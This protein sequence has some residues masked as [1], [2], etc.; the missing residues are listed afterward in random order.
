[1]VTLVL[2][3]LTQPL[4]KITLESMLFRLAPIQ[5]RFQA[6]FVGFVGLI[7]CGSSF[8]NQK[9]VLPKHDLHQT[10]FFLSIM[11][12]LVIGWFFFDFYRAIP[13]PTGFLGPLFF[14]GMTGPQQTYLNTKHRSPQEVF[15]GLG[16]IGGGCVFCLCSF[17][18]EVFCFPPPK[19]SIKS[20]HRKIC[21]IH[22]V[23]PPRKFN[24]SPSKQSY[25]Q[26]LIFQSLSFRG[27]Q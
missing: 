26:G 24:M 2:K 3:K 5:Q 23:F 16:Q 7:L 6:F 25:L 15:R 14:G 1:M 18:K 13:N 4:P 21:P 17:K 19:N 27:E 20:T 22:F 12:N 11:D 9:K 8:C 10:H